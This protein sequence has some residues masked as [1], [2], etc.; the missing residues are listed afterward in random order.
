MPVVNYPLDTTG[1]SVGNLIHDEVHTL[2]EIN[3]STYRILI[4][5]FAPFYLD[6]FLLTHVDGVGTITNLVAGVD[7]YECLPYIGATRSI[8]KTVYGGISINTLFVNGVIKITYQT[9]GGDWTADA[10]YV[11]TRLAEM[12]YNPRTT[13]WDIVTNKPNQFPPI[14]HDQDVDFIYGQGDLIAAINGIATNIIN[15][16]DQGVPIVHHLVDVSNPHE[17]TKA[18]VG[19]DLVENL[20]VATHDEVVAGVGLDKYI[21]LRQLVDVGLL[22]A[23]ISTIEAHMADVEN[24]HFVT[25]TQVGLG[26]VSNLPVADALDI[27]NKSPLDKYITLRQMVDLGLLSLGTTVADH[28]ANEANPHV[29]TKAQVGLPDLADLQMATDSEVF[30]LAGVDKYITLRQAFIA[31]SSANAASPDGTFNPMSSPELYYLSKP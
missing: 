16:P 10:D 4:P 27:T 21:T 7:Y 15:G 25:K 17:T 23:D 13:V 6:N 9:L 20:P 2:T 28:N 18:Q 24:P 11:L 8:G 22:S 31:I 5:Q 3:S 14:N 1:I 19:L 29:V 26:N 12:V 30:N